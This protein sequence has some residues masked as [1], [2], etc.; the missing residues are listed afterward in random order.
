MLMIVGCGD[1][2]SVVADAGPEGAVTG[3]VHNSSLDIKEVV[4]A[5]IM[6]TT[7]TGTPSTNGAVL[8]STT[9]GLCAELQANTAH[10]NQKFVLLQLFDVTSTTFTAPSVPGTYTVITP[11]T[12][13]PFPTTFAEVHAWLTDDNCT[14]PLASDAGGNSGSVTVTAVNGNTYT[15]TFDVNLDTNEHITGSF[16]P[17]ECPALHAWLGSNTP[18]TCL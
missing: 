2:S 14:A 5:N 6:S 18:P 13:P 1:G 7:S 16:T 15:G 17:T 3:T 4:S 9:T 10:P 8:L 12:Q 11:T